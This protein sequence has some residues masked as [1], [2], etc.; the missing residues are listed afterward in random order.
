MTQ[1][2][3]FNL[4]WSRRSV[5]RGIQSAVVFASLG[6]ACRQ[7]GSEL[8]MHVSTQES[9]QPLAER[10]IAFLQTL[11]PDQRRRAVFSFDAA[12]RFN[13]HYV[14][15]SREG[16]AFKE[17]TAE[18]RSAAEALLKFALSDVGYQ[19]AQNIFT[20]ESV[21]RQLGGS[22]QFRDPDQYAFTIFGDPNAPPW[23]WRIEGHHLSLN[24]T[25]AASDLVAVTPAFFGANPAR[26]TIPP[27]E[28]LR[29]LAREQDLAFELV[30]HL[31]DTQQAQA[32]LAD[33]SFGDILTGPIRSQT[34]ERPAGLPL[35]DL[36]EG[37][38]TL[39]MQLIEDY[40]R[41]MRG[42]YAD[43]QLQRIADAGRDRIHFAWAGSLTPGQPHY[44]RLHGPVLLIE[45]DNTQNNANHIHTVMR[46][47]TDDFGEDT[48][49]AHYEHGGHQVEG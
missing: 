2:S 37:R 26:V 18:Q 20:L 42:D 19:K 32:V 27:H 21:L 28:G 15:R 24:F 1:F 44:Y 10:A 30:R 23:G 47:P 38:R 22:A 7:S 12:E 35:S 17:M 39:A 9:T 48:L 5:L 11:D 31:T 40:V 43:A 41:T 36:D 34:L 45:Y 16:I 3:R 13:W 49:R 46:D 14:P 29:T 4:P 8:P 33:Q 25:I 6:V